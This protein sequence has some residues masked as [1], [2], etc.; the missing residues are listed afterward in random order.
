M[1]NLSGFKYRDVIKKLKKFGLNLRGRLQAAMKF[2]LTQPQTDIQQFPTI[3]V[4]YR[5]EH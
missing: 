1:G 4:I 2:G 3:Q 5:K